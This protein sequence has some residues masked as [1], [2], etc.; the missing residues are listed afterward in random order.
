LKKRFFYIALLVSLA[1]SWNHGCLRAQTVVADSLARLLATAPPDTH[2][3]SMLVDYAFE[4]NELQTEVANSKLQ[5]ALA[6]AKQLED[7]R[8]EAAAING[9]GLIEEI[10]GDY[11][12]A[13]TL[14]QQAL[15]LR[16]SIGDELRAAG[17]L[18]NLGNAYESLGDL[19]SAIS[20][21]RQSLALYERLHNTTRMARA[22]SNIAGVLESTGEYPGAFT[23]LD[24]ARILL[25][26]ENDPFTIAKI[27]TK[28]GHN[29]FEMD[30]YPEAK[31][32]YRKSLHLRQKLNNRADLAEG[33]TDMGNALDE[34]EN[35]DSSWLAVQ[36][37]NQ[38]LVIYNAINDQ[39]SIGRIYNNLGDAYKHLNQLDKALYYLRKAEKIQTE[40]DDQP[41]LMQTYN[42]INDVFA[43]QDRNQESLDYIRRYAAIADS[44][45]SD[46]YR[47]GAL[48]DFAR[49]YENL[50]DFEK[51][52]KYQ[53]RYNDL[54]Y[55]LL[56]E[57]RAKTVETQQAKR[58]A[59]ENEIALAQEKAALALKD[60]EY[61]RARTF[62]I[63]LFGGLLALL[64]LA[65][66]LFNRNR[67][68][69]R[70]NRELASKNKA[71]EHERKRA[72]ELL[73]NI[74]PAETAEELKRNN[75]VKPV[76]YDSVT[77]LFSDFKDFTRIAERISPEAL[78]A[79]LDG[80]FRLFDSIIEKNG[81]EKI[82]TIGDAYMCAGGLPVRN[83]THALDTVTAAI[84]MQRALQAISTQKKASGQPVFEM[85]IGIHTGPVVAGVVGIHKFA[86]DIWG[87]TVNTA[88]R[89]EQSGEAGKI[90]LSETT[91]QL[92]KHRF[93][94]TPR[95]KLTAKNKGEIEMYFVEAVGD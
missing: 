37:Y 18:I 52:Y 85:R 31:E 22:Y 35:T 26:K 23:E 38:A 66:L 90:N 83:E 80:F 28:L 19:A 29:R 58:K 57:N 59:D 13:I 11:A 9:L 25:E 95:G 2:R 5:E 45:G 6:L 67:I 76:R 74:L 15:A 79:E 1:W 12:K 33:L 64:L 81:L 32:W 40:L 69:A 27:Y 16:Q 72:D 68:R 63:A 46:K 42:T 10:R 87:D 78:V 14:Y 77:V 84:E 36:L 93:P 44:I 50:G 8:V 94:C 89:M 3:V 47:L 71:I 70:A 82:K 62:N 24:K 48:K 17:T 30:Q 43:R 60:S 75:S 20:C 34:L 49:A 53:V 21:H 65:L 54:R 51:A 39:P 86:Y 88:A 7:P 4:I 41:G 92:V 73:K 91:Y 61:A 55:Q 56:N